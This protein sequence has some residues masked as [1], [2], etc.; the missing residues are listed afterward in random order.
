MYKWLV[1]LLLIISIQANAGIF[2]TYKTI[3]DPELEAAITLPVGAFFIVS[4][5]LSI[6]YGGIMP[7]GLGA[8]LIVLD[9]GDEEAGLEKSLLEMFPY[10]D[11]YE[12]SLADF[13]LANSKLNEETSIPR[14][15]SEEFLLEVGDFSDTEIDQISEMLD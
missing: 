4:G 10:V 3:Q 6:R 9:E 12:K 7:V 8:L 2:L 13:I 1:S 11:G 14:A 5:A 15:L